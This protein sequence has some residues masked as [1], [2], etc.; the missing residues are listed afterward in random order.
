MVNFPSKKKKISTEVII[1]TIWIST[2]LAM[3]FTIP[4]LGIFLGIYY[5]TGNL[6][7]GAVLG[8]STHFVAL[9][10]SGR[11]SKFLTKIMN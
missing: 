7:L 6:V 2:F 5:S 4:A 11:I 10:F 1:N 8:F 3:I 9:A